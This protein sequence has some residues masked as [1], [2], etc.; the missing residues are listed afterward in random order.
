M[1]T[2]QKNENYS[3]RENKRQPFDKRLIKEIVKAVEEGT[4]RRDMISRHGM[5][6]GTLGEW[7]CKY[8]SIAYQGSSRQVY[9]S[10]HKRTILRAI[11]SG[12]TI[13]TA[14]ISFGVKHA[15]I[16]RHWV[17]EAKRENIELSLCKPTPMAK[18]SDNKDSD[19][20]KALKQSL[21]DAQLKIQALDTM[22]D[23]AEEQLKINIRKK[24]GAKQSPK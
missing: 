4:P 8:G 23:I 1:E 12:M 19:E 22:I 2:T 17:R 9:S 16:V 3:K 15:A 10:S 11:E 24:S 5:T 20:V 18:P 13:K 7:M 14:Q 21:A 6:K